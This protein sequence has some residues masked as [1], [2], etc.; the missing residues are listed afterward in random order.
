MGKWQRGGKETL[1]LKS[2]RWRWTLTP[3]TVLPLPF[4]VLH[5]TRPHSHAPLPLH[6]YIRGPV[7]RCVLWVAG[8]SDAPAPPRPHL[9]HYI[10]RAAKYC[11]SENNIT[12]YTTLFS[13]RF[14]P[15][16]WECVCVSL[17]VLWWRK[18]DQEFRVTLPI[19]LLWN[20]D[21]DRLG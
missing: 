6:P 7:C 15:G 14:W 16:V 17:K 12:I 19:L 18:Q 4:P 13:A 9:W 8:L 10:W 3:R 1:V 21:Q 5:G 11:G 2:M 20:C